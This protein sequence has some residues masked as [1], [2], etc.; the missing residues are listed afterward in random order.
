MK[1]NTHDEAAAFTDRGA[2]DERSAEAPRELPELTE[3]WFDKPRAS[4]STVPPP[5][6]SAPPIGDLL[7]D[8][9]FR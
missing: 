1:T 7:A 2:D 8:D 3:S 4:V 5:R 6:K 9:W